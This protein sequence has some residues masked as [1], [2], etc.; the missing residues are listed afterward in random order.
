VIEMNT[1]LVSFSGKNSGRVRFRWNFEK[2]QNWDAKSG[3]K[4]TSRLEV[5]EFDCKEKRYRHSALTLF[6]AS[7]KTL[8]TEEL[9]WFGPWTPVSYQSFIK[10]LYDPA[11]RL[12]QLRRN[13]PPS[14]PPAEIP[15]APATAGSLPPAEPA[16][17]EPKLKKS[18]APAPHQ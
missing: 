10:R 7:G 14:L 1:Q 5:I 11:C 2:P 6:D 13:L 16:R 3:L 18:S 8:H 15:G 12:L 4:F 17:V 9:D